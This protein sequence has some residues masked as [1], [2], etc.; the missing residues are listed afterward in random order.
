[1]TFHL[2]TQYQELNQLKT[3][4]CQTQWDLQFMGL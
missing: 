4:Y 3:I 1:M 2:P